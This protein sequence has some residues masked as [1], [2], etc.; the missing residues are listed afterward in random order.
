M[1]VTR[2]SLLP[3]HLPASGMDRSSDRIRAGL[4]SFLVWFRAL[5]RDANAL[6]W[7]RDG[8]SFWHPISNGAGFRLHEV[9][10]RMVWPE[11]LGLLR[12]AFG[13][14]ADALLCPVGDN[15]VEIMFVDCLRKL[16]GLYR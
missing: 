1:P 13:G 6:L 16:T 14:I 15:I 11:Y 4:G 9:D 10:E 8:D 7:S 5:P 2:W 12:R 3:S